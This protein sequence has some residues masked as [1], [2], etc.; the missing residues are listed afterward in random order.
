VDALAGAIRRLSDGAT[1]VT[2]T[3]EPGIGKT[4][5][6]QQVAERAAQSGATVIWGT[7]LETG[8]SRPYGVFATS[9]FPDSAETGR[10]DT[11]RPVAESLSVIRR[12]IEALSEGPTTGAE[13][14]DATVDKLGVQE[15]VAEWCRSLCVPQP[16]VIILD[17]M[18]W[19]DASS[20]DLLCYLVDF[21]SDA[22]VLFVVIRREAGPNEEAVLHEDLDRLVREKSNSELRLGGLNLAAVRQLVSLDHLPPELADAIWEQTGGNPYHV[23]ELLAD[24]RLRVAAPSFAAAPPQDLAVAD[25]IVALLSLDQSAAAAIPGR[26]ESPSAGLERLI[27][28]RLAGI[29]TNANLFLTGASACGNEFDQTIAAK[30]V[31]LNDQEGASAAREAFEARLI[32]PGEVFGSFQFCHPL[33]RDAILASVSPARRPQLHRDIAHAIE[34]VAGPATSFEQLATLGRHYH[35]SRAL[36]GRESGAD[37]AILAAR[38]AEAVGAHAESA[39]HLRVALELIDQDDDRRADLLQ[40]RAL[41]LAWALQFHQAAS[42]A[43]LGAD[44]L[45]A[46]GRV[47]LAVER[48]AEAALA[49]YDAGN[50]GRARALAGKGLELG[51]SEKTTSWAVMWLLYAEQR[52]KEAVAAGGVPTYDDNR[53]IAARLIN[54]EPQEWAF[55]YGALE[56]GFDSRGHVLNQRDAPPAA[57][58]DRAG[59]FI[60]AASAWEDQARRAERAGRVAMAANAWANAARAQIALGNLNE[61][62]GLLSRSAERSRQVGDES[63]LIPVQLGAYDERTMV[64]GD[65]T[66]IAAFQSSSPDYRERMM[67]TL[68]TLGRGV[69]AGSYARHVAWA[70]DQQTALEFLEQAIGPVMRAPL[71]MVTVPRVACDLAEVLWVLDQ[72]AHLEDLENCL[73]EKVIAPDFRLPMRDSR[74]SMAR[75]CALSGRYDE[76]R[77]WFGEAR[78][79]LDNQGARPLRAIVDFDEA[80]MLVR[81]GDPVDRADASRL[82]ADASRRFDH[83]GM[84]GWQVRAAELGRV[85]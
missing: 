8:R 1:L 75:L 60:G 7:C 37:P 19:A 3:G 48:L 64:R 5:L 45:V 24:V 42:S 63:W 14:V 35:E 20:C 13:G 22:P 62:D 61:A 79:V 55:P 6:A 51:A 2:I 31:G 12:V 67:A 66:P 16:L 34:A 47:D 32:E 85:P 59:D 65:V 76:A 81:R 49:L 58:L 77:K 52:D 11:A 9:V 4:R 73:R 50:G 69:L 26:Q 36:P 54:R 57:L 27:A 23:G 70:G 25:V 17:D 40:Q 18:Q 39:N 21:L 38:F 72:T 30:S 29:S 46:A 53:R 15:A 43:E 28:R 82:L 41:A 44:L 83:L 68:D 71:W 84:P 78:K 56:S 80:K 10:R 33:I 74:L